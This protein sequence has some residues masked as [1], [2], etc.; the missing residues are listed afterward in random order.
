MLALRELQSAFV[1]AVQG[2]TA[3]A[4]MLL[5]H[6]AGGRL[7]PARRLEV[8]ANTVAVNRRNV[9]R[10]VYPVVERLVGEEFFAYAADSFARSFPSQSGNLDDYGAEFPDFL[11][12]FA[13]AAYLPYLP[14]VARLELTIDRLTVAADPSPLA[15][16]VEAIGGDEYFALSP[17]CR[18]VGSSFPVLR[19]WQVNQPERDGNDIVDLGQGPAYLLVYRNGFVVEI[20]EIGP[21]EF[22]LLSRLAAGVSAGAAIAAALERAADF[23]AAASLGRRLAD[24]TLYRS[25]ACTSFS[26]GEHHGL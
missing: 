12:G 22:T 4:D 5:D 9:L 18:L 26:N 7:S 13:P 1:A 2:D 17:A 14:D 16:T 24:G 21:A 20:A 23:D 19:I 10:A 6:V 3:R 8:Y 15:R 25:A 11:A